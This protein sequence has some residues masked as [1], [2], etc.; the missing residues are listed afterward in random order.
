MQSPSHPSGTRPIASPIR[1]LHCIPTLTIGGAETQLKLLA[2][3]LAADPAFEIGVF[4]R[5]ADADLQALTASGV[6]CFPLHSRGNYDPAILTTLVR[7]LRTWRPTVIQT[8]LTQM[9]ILAGSAALLGRIPWIIAERS[10]PLAYPPSFRNRLRRWLGQHASLV[11]NAP[12]GLD[13]WP[14][15]RSRQ[16]IANG[17]DFASL[18]E[19]RGQASD[20]AASPRAAFNIVTISRLVREKNVETLIRAI[21]LARDS[22]PDIQLT[23]VGDGPDRA[24]L[25]SLVVEQDLVRHVTFVGFQ[26]EPVAWLR[27]ADA[28]ASA[29][30]F[31]GHPNA[32][33]EAAATGLPTILSDISMHRSL[34]MDAALYAQT[35]NPVVFAGHFISLAND[36]AERAAIVDRAD[37]VIERFDIDLV[38][39]KY[40]ALYRHLATQRSA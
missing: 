12:Q 24:R 40:A 4:G 27:S 39:A 7:T 33:T 23:V 5:F 28:F 1:V 10:S 13:V 16:V 22:V 31:E 11:A 38:T 21:A 35:E 29:S 8:W 37:R 36:P 19:G 26:T 32:V 30:L 34:M 14:D 25:E 15:H 20:N 3:R 2:P 6:R 18:R 9:D 17:V